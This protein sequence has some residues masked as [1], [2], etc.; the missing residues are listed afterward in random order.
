MASGRV[1]T[2]LLSTFQVPVITIGQIKKFF[3]IAIAYVENLKR[4]IAH[5]LNRN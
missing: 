1:H 5:V 4:D 2:F 3:K